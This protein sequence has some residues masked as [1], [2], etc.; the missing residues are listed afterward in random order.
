MYIDA[1]RVTNAWARR[2][3]LKAMKELVWLSKYI[4]KAVCLKK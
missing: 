3:T 4:L 2:N 1:W